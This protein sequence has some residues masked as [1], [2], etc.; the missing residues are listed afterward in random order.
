MA[1]KE[2][3]TELDAQF[4]SDKATPTTWREARDLLEAAE[5]YW[6]ST[7]RPDGSPHV[8]PLIGIWHDGAL[9]FC[10]GPD[11]RKAKNLQSNPR[12]VMTA[13]GANSLTKG[14]DVVVEG[15]AVL[16]HDEARLRRLAE[17]YEAKYGPAWHFDVVDG[18]F[19]GEGGR[20]LVFAVAPERAFGFARESEYGQTRW[21]F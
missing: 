1:D 13:G 3:V 10:T 14:L 18:A 8:T 11:E 9:H 21:L 5:I 4:S 19:A 7:V 6:L 17:A 16:V 12:C 20:A 15:Q 2:P